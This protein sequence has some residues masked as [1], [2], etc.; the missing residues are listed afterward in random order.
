MKNWKCPHCNSGKRA[1]ERPRQNDVRRYCLPCSE[2]TGRLVERVCPALNAARQRK[3][4]VHKE[5]RSRKR[6][7]A[8]ETD[9]RRYIAGGVDVRDVV[10]RALRLP[11]VLAELRI[12]H[13]DQARA[14]QP[15][16]HVRRTRCQPNSRAGTAWPREYRMQIVSWPSQPMNCL[17]KTVVHECVHLA[18]PPG[19]GHGAAFKVT[20][21]EAI[22]EWNKRYPDES[23]HE[24][25]AA[26]TY[27]M[28][29]KP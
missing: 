20:M 12:N 8:R 23:L 18:L 17:R 27:Y 21:R 2:R 26:W 11:S 29:A 15:R 4:A 7:Y 14:G 24:S 22:R 6:E 9:A 16:I 19:E 5:R 25:D 1:P 3:H 28:E 10:K 13:P